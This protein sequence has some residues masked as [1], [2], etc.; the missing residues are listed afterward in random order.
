MR[1]PKVNHY[2]CT[3]P[4]VYDPKINKCVVEIPKCVVDGCPEG[5][6]C[7]QTVGQC[8]AMP[9]SATD[10]NIPVMFGSS[11]I[12]EP[13]SWQSEY[14]KMDDA[15]QEVLE[16]AGDE[17][18]WGVLAHRAG[19]SVATLKAVAD[20]FDPAVKEKRTAKQRAYNLGNH[21]GLAAVLAQELGV[22]SA[23]SQSGRP[24]KT[25]EPVLLPVTVTSKKDLPSSAVELESKTATVAKAA[26]NTTPWLLIGG[27]A[28]AFYLMTRR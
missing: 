7:N 9:G 15:N 12:A 4:A 28:L 22:L 26:E 16:P 1:G 11:E 17:Y 25:F 18:S 14:G 6:Y 27:A 5:F 24:L 3:P 23:D 8:M 19:V 20:N 21:K 13:I 2:N 10:D